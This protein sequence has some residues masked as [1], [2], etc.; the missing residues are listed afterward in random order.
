V[1]LTVYQ[2][3]SFAE[4]DAAEDL[5]YGALP[6][7]ERLKILLDLVESHR[8]ACGPDAERF[9]RIYRVVELERG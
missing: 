9:E 7:Q 6:P 1:D 2:Y 4:A 3:D 8:L 5:F